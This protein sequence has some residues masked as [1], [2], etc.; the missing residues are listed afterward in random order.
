METAMDV[1]KNCKLVW[2]DKRLDASGIY[3]QDINPSGQLGQPVIPVELISFTA[4]VNGLDVILKW[5]TL[6]E[7]N[8]KGFEIERSLSKNSLSKHWEKIGFAEGSGT[9]T[10]LTAY[11]FAD[12]NIPTGNVY[13]RLKQIDFDGTFEYSNYIE[14]EV[15][16]PAEFML[17]QNFPNPFNP[18][19]MIQ[20]Q[21]ALNSNVTLKI[22][23]ALGNEVSTLLNEYQPA[24]TYQIEYNP[25]GL[26]SSVYFYQLKADNFIQTKKMLLLK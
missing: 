3:A 8:N 16:S 23:D 26:T 10:E 12:K 22:Y 1:Y 7:T 21:L 18:S 2:G 17:Y 15:L 14:I 5:T 13:Y 11:S 6:T 25:A 20:Y 24:G 19:T 9:T 4:T